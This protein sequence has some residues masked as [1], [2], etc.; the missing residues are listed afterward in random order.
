MEPYFKE[1]GLLFSTGME[2]LYRIAEGEPSAEKMLERLE[3]AYQEGVKRV[4]KKV[5]REKVVPFCQ[6]HKLD[7]IADMGTWDVRAPA[8]A[9]ST[10]L[11]GGNWAGDPA[12]DMEDWGGVDTNAAGIVD[13]V[14]EH[15]PEGWAELLEAIELPTNAGALGSFMPDYRYGGEE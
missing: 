9:E 8:C 14:H 12:W 3:K 1:L 15:A 10:E 5:W 11:P 7:F 6:K 13:A 4:A 2:M